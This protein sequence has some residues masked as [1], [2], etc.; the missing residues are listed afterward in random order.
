MRLQSPTET[1]ILGIKTESYLC[2]VHMS[3]EEA[4]DV[5]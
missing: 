2:A 1:Y 3:S 4:A 5:F